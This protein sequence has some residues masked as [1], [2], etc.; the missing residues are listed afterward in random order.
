MKC[1]HDD[2]KRS[3]ES[4]LQKTILIALAGNP[5]V[6]KSTV[7]NALT[8]SKQRIANYPGVTV[9]KKLGALKTKNGFEAKVIDLPGCYSLDPQSQDE[10]IA[11]KAI[12]GELPDLSV[13]IVVVIAEAAKLARGL[14]LVQ[15]VRAYNKNVILALNMMDELKKKQLHINTEKLK[16]L[17]NIPIVEMVATKRRGIPD[18]IQVLQTVSKTPSDKPCPQIDS[19]AVAKEVTQKTSASSRKNVSDGFD[20]ILLH[21]IFGPLIFLTIMYYLFKSLFT[22][23]VP[24]MDL[25]DN[26]VTM[27]STFAGALIT[28]TLLKS[29]VIDGIIAG[30]GSVI[31]FVPQIAMTFFFIGIMEM[32]GYMARGGFLIDRFM[33]FVGLEGRA[34]IPLMSSFACA[35]PGIL[36]T[37]TLPNAKQ[38]LMTILIAPF[39][40]CSA[41]LPVYT[42]LIATFIPNTLSYV[43]FQ[44]QG[45]T[46]LGL[47]LLGILAGMVVS[48]LFSK[49]LQ[50]KHKTSF[51]MELPHYRLPTLKNLYYY[52]SHRT[53][54]FL[55]TAGTVIF[56]LSLVLWALA[57]FPHSSEIAK[58]YETKRIELATKNFEAKQ[59][60]SDLASLNNAE[61]GDYL[62]ASYMGQLGRFLEPVFRPMG[63]DWKLGIGVIASFAAREVFVSTM[64]IVFNLGSVDETNEGLREKLQTAQLADG[65][66]AYT[67][68]TAIALLIFF[69]LAS[70]CL[71]T[72]AVIRRETNSW[73]WPLFTF[74]YM[75]VLAF[76]AATTVYQGLGFLG[77]S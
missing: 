36:A 75:S 44:A 37:R 11:T 3:P 9:E 60:D 6:G 34:F 62:R 15:S 64:G 68:R 57:Y 21:P 67:L 33:R 30:V 43:G 10:E 7:F 20:K 32:S 5:N 13:D 59:Y 22:W 77:I 38:R 41:R 45:L 18:L 73:K 69:A 47:F 49:I 71:S 53:F 31:V 55:R 58:N 28:N 63:L 35:I 29:L 61:A 12:R 39:M 54:T 26:G 16:N 42:L 74:I 1:C 24:L 66:R 19:D 17:L 27:L 76:V 72:L 70:Q 51:F 48:F 50:N 46:L 14:R 65:S 56:G 52:I 2:T 23:A 25:I 40:T 4:S 8:G